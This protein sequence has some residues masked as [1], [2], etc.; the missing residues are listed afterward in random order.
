[1]HNIIRMK[2][3]KHNMYIFLEMDEIRIFF[4]FSNSIH[5]TVL[6]GF[7][8]CCRSAI[9]LEHTEQYAIPMTSET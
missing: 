2:I 4:N 7:L 9:N 8:A 3:K 1:M 5:Y 6:F